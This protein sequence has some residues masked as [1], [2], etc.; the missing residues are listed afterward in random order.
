[1]ILIPAVAKLRCNQC[2]IVIVLVGFKIA[3]DVIEAFST[4]GWM[5]YLGK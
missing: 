3:R 4:E 2:N 1:M 5:F